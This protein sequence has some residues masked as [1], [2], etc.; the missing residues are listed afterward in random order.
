MHILIKSLLLYL[1][2][3]A[4][5]YCVFE[6]ART[7]L[8]K[9]EEFIQPEEADTIIEQNPSHKASGGIISGR[10]NYFRYG[11]AALFSDQKQVRTM[12]DF[13]TWITDRV[14]IWPSAQDICCSTLDKKLEVCHC[15]N[16]FV[17]NSSCTDNTPYFFGSHVP[18]RIEN[19]LGSD[20][21][22]MSILGNNY[23]LSKRAIKIQ[24]SNVTVK[25][26]TGDGTY[27]KIKLTRDAIYL[28]L[29]RPLMMSFG[30]TGLYEV[31]HEDSRFPTK[32]SDYEGGK[33]A[34]AF[35]YFDSDYIPSD[36]SEEQNPRN[37]PASIYLRQIDDPAM[38]PVS[39]NAKGGAGT[40]IAKY[41]NRSYNKNELTCTIYYINYVSPIKT[42]DKTSN[43]F[44]FYINNT[45]YNTVFTENETSQT[46]Y[47]DASENSE[48]IS[49]IK[50][51]RNIDGN[52]QVELDNTSFTF[53]TDFA[54]YEKD[55]FDLFIH[56]SHEVLL[57]VGFS[58]HKNRTR[59]IVKRYNL[60]KRL[61]YNQETL[62]STFRTQANSAY[63]ALNRLIPIDGIPNFAS[64][65][66]RLGYVA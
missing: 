50:V 42:S 20:N 5:A 22:M 24:T 51:K 8:T 15:D 6:L 43:V 34:N 13:E 19:T 17:Q 33:N 39:T 47:T 10:F 1:L 16:Y 44:N 49:M 31:I 32:G 7:R 59:V 53:P 41:Y 54:F 40:N 25:N 26:G 12:P 21:C 2:I 30:T 45:I 56:I 60:D 52:M 38:Y 36:F 63:H 58:E 18:A 23:K 28:V 11:L 35:A 48:F 3:L 61:E 62:S 64:L 46:F 27:Y 29:I 55:K 4:L 66:D 14:Y 65:F 9:T 57:L 37:S